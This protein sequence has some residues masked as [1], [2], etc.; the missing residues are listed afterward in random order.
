MLITDIPIYTSYFAKSKEIITVGLVPISIALQTPAW[1]DGLSVDKLKPTWDIIR[2][3][4]RDNN[5][6]DYEKSYYGLLVDRYGVNNDNI[7][8]LI[9]MVKLITNDIINYYKND[10]RFNGLCFMCY[11]SPEKFCHRQLLVKWLMQ[12]GFTVSEYLTK[13]TVSEDANKFRSTNQ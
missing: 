9:D 13:H 3:Y 10:R 6:H 2:Q 8:D 5:V 4:K 7:P 12:Q 1:F 11:E